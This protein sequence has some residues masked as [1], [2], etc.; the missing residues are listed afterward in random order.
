MRSHL[1]CLNDKQWAMFKHSNQ[2]TCPRTVGSHCVSLMAGIKQLF[3]GKACRGDPFRKSLRQDHIPPVNPGPAN[4]N[5][6]AGH[7]KKPIG[8]IA[9]CSRLK[10][11]HCHA[12]RQTR[13]KLFSKKSASVPIFPQCP[14]SHAFTQ[15]PQSHVCAAFRSL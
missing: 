13:R 1:F 8:V 15:S 6:R 9:C 4:R 7:D 11:A 2:S 10:E 3:G 12:L 14:E 5:K